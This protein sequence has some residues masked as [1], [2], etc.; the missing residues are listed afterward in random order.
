MTL[1]RGRPPK[2]VLSVPIYIDSN[3]TVH[4]TGW[5]PG[6]ARN[7]GKSEVELCFEPIYGN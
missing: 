6:Q 3:I 4:I 5:I 1:L 2:R 7:D